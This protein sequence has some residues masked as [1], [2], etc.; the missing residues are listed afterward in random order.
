[1]RKDN[2]EQLSG[3]QKMSI[4]VAFPSLQII[5]GRE[6]IYHKGF[7]QG[8]TLRK[9]AL[10]IEVADVPSSFNNKTVGPTCQSSK[11][12]KFHIVEALGTTSQ[13]KSCHR[14]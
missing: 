13:Q 6:G 9:E 2:K 7:P 8:R 1:M 12:I 14:R 3:K 5:G 4:D 11:R 10:R